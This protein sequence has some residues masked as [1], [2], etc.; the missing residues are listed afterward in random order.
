MAYVEVA[1]MANH[2]DDQ[3]V[4]NQPLTTKF[5]LLSRVMRHGTYE[6]R[7]R[8]L[9]LLDM[10]ASDPRT[11]ML[12]LIA[13]EDPEPM[14][15]CRAL[16]IFGNHN[17][18]HFKP[19][20][21][22]FLR[23]SHPDIRRQ[24]VEM[25]GKLHDPDLLKPLLE[26]LRDRNHLVRCAAVEAVCWCETDA[27]VEGLRPLI[28]DPELVVR[29]RVCEVF[30]RL[31]PVPVVD[32]LDRLSDE[33]EW[34]RFW[35]IQVLQGSNDPWAVSGII[36]C[37]NDASEVVFTR[38]VR[39]LGYLK[40]GEAVPYLEDSLMRYTDDSARTRLVLS[41]L[42]H[43]GTSQAEEVLL[44]W[45]QT[46]DAEAGSEPDFDSLTEAAPDPPPYQAVEQKKYKR[47]LVGKLITF[48]RPS[49]QPEKSLA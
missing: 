34:V 14:I 25:L 9:H 16:T 47:S 36:S 31:K 21:V 22:E 40:A 19:R 29:R 37:L 6:E 1:H 27:V 2:P 7:F 30:T 35:C 23:D 24:A 3:L 11:A 42:R 46:R 15:R 10:H 28:H 18:H 39:T 48:L 41:V 26:C 49:P 8:V 20:I 38:A 4:D 33:D 12:L 5:R 17:I 45:R 32:L 43:I 44:R 13:L